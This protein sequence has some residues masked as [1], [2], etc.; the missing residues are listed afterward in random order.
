MAKQKTSYTLRRDRTQ[1]FRRTVRYKNGS[2]AVLVFQ[3]GVDIELT[4]E[5]VA[6]L[7]NEIEC[8]MVVVTNR[9]GK[10]RQRLTRPAAAPAEELELATA[11]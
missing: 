8:G 7:K 5:E 2:T 6:F 10:G 1:E 3:P 9:D 4:A 11:E